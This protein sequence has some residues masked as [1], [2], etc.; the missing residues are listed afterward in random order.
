MN[1]KIK[2]LSLLIIALISTN[3]FALECNQTKFNKIRKEINKFIFLYKKSLTTE[4][5]RVS[6]IS[7]DN[8]DSDMKINKI[9]LASLNEKKASLLLASVI[10]NDNINTWK[11]LKKTCQGKDLIAIKIQKEN[12]KNRKVLVH[13]LMEHIN[14]S[15]ENKK[16]AIKIAND[17][18]ELPPL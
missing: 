5:E 8:H 13:K 11:A 9:T 16:L 15:I 3:L 1:L 4:Q 2:T 10:N 12:S 7:K 6:H 18:H 14:I 17:E